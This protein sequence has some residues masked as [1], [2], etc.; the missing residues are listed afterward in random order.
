[1]RDGKENTMPPARVHPSAV[2]AQSARLGDG[3]VVGPFC[4][5]GP[6]VEVGAGSE[7]VAHAT[8]LGPLRMGRNNRVFPYACLGGA[9]Q[10]RSF[11]GEESWLEVADDNVFREHVTVH[12]GTRKGGGVTRIGS[13]GLFMVGVHVAHD[14]SVADDVT[15]TN[16]ATLGGHVQIGRG[17]VCAGHVAIAPFVRLGQSCFVA[18]GAQVERDVP[19]FVIAAG[20]RAR[21]RALNEVGLERAGVP[22]SSRAAL[23]QAFRLLFRSGIPLE[24]AVEQAHLRFAGD[25]FVRELVQFLQSRAAYRRRV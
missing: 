2:V 19:P 5:V 14:A 23:K 12:R 3:V 9:P 10:D 8:L 4:H 24:L 22:E 11:A 13:R 1:V 17:A 20:D 15:L 21:V 6:D 16:L 18:G 7:L 25:A